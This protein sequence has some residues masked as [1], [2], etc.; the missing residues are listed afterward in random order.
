MADINTTGRFMRLLAE[1]S[2]FSSLHVNACAA[3]PHSSIWGVIN[4]HHETNNSL[5][6][7]DQL[8]TWNAMEMQQDAI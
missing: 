3:F 6:Y 7:S 4:T 5:E 8:A 2:N 1:I